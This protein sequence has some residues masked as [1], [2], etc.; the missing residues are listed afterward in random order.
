MRKLSDFGIFKIDDVIELGS[1]RNILRSRFVL[2]AKFTIVM[3]KPIQ[4]ISNFSK[5]YFLSTHHL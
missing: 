3:F 5:T 4:I 2:N 1:I